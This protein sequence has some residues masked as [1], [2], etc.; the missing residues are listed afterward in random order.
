MLVQDIATETAESVAEVIYPSLDFPANTPAR[1]ERAGFELEDEP[2]VEPRAAA[3]ELLGEFKYIAAA[4]SPRDK[5]TQDDL[6]QEMCLAA[7]EC[8]QPNRLSYYLW[9][10]GWRAKD[11]LRW[12]LTP[13]KLATE[14]ESVVRQSRARK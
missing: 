8:A 7:L 5:S 11:Y 14:N 6:V 2:L 10:A 3:V 1:T 12:W 9:L 4:L 13:M